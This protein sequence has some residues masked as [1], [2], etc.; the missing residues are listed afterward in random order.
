MTFGRAYLARA[1][2]DLSQA[3][4]LAETLIAAAES[5]A[6]ANADEPVPMLLLLR[7]RVYADLGRLELAEGDFRPAIQAASTHGERPLVWRLRTALAQVL[8]RQG[9]Q[10]EAAQEFERA[11][12]MAAELAD[13]LPDAKLQA[14]F[15]V[16]SG[17]F[18]SRIEELSRHDD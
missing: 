11:R 9:R 13:G 17:L 15:R 2:G 3:L 10:D 6:P 16:Q 12:A 14:N 4:Q 8:E 1:R 18:A 7:G 5:V